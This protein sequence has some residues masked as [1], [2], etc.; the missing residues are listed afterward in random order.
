MK[1]NEIIVEATNPTNPPQP[2][3]KEFD[4]SQEFIKNIILGNDRKPGQPN[5]NPARFN[6]A[7][8]YKRAL[9]NV[10]RY[11]TGGN[12]TQADVEKLDLNNADF[13]RGPVYL[14]NKIASFAP[15]L[16]QAWYNNRKEKATAQ[17]QP[18]NLKTPKNGQQATLSGQDDINI[19]YQWDNNA[20]K[21]VTKKG[22]GNPANKETA[23][24]L[25]KQTGTVPPSQGN[26]QQIATNGNPSED[27]LINFARASNYTN[28]GEPNSPNF[29]K[30]LLNTIA[31][32][33]KRKEFIS[34]LRQ[35]YSL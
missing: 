9:W 6:D 32:D 28:Q 2:G 22:I 30:Y 19:T 10:L 8:Q 21:M 20:W 4:A 16:T 26:S 25:F 7:E 3:S 15:Q 13:A 31:D 33:N 1:A 35:L 17:V 12:L 34:Q 29:V 11:N 18:S 14:Q 23:D 27:I 5:I 24:E